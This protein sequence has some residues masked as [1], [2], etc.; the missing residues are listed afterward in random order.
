MFQNPGYATAGMGHDLPQ[1][2]LLAT[3][4]MHWPASGCV[5]AVVLVFQKGKTDSEMR[6]VY[7]FHFPEWPDKMAPKDEYIDRI[8]D[9]IQAVNDKRTQLRDSRSVIVHCR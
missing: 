5:A 7:H 1:D 3:N 2:P 6:I 8:L 4:P 9:F